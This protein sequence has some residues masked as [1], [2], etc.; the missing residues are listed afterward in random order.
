MPLPL[1]FVNREFANQSRK[2]AASFM[3]ALSD[4][5][6]AFAFIEENENSDAQM[7]IGDAES[8]LGDAISE[9]RSL[10]PVKDRWSIRNEAVFDN[11]LDNLADKLGFTPTG[12]R[13]VIDTLMSELEQLRALLARHTSRRPDSATAQPI[14]DSD[15]GQFHLTSELLRQVIRV[16]EIGVAATRLSLVSGGDG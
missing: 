11:A 2:P 8:K 13:V 5:Y 15:E 14:P 3:R 9:L 1:N 16:Q 12:D 4:L 7:R 10:E 6:Q